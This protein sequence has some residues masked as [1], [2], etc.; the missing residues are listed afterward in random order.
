MKFLNYLF[1]RIRNSSFQVRFLYSK[2][3][4]DID[5]DIF[6]VSNKRKEIFKDIKLN[7]KLENFHLIYFH[8]SKLNYFVFRC[9]LEYSISNFY[10][11]ERNIKNPMIYIE[12]MINI[13]QSSIVNILNGECKDDLMKFLSFSKFGLGEFVNAYDLS[14]LSKKLNNRESINIISNIFIDYIK[15]KYS[16]EL[17]EKPIREHY[18]LYDDL[19]WKSDVII[20]KTYE[21]LLHNNIFKNK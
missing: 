14:V 18:D 16:F 12:D 17:Y 6:I 5:I 21:K 10:I 3:Y 4:N 15:K 19:I 8:Y 2:N 1:L 7:G 13:Y 9:S 20:R 11:G